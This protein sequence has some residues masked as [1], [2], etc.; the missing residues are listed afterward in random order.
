MIQLDVKTAGSHV[1]FHVLLPA[2]AEPRSV[3]H[4]GL[5]LPFQ[6]AD[7]EQSRYVNFEVS[8]ARQARLDIALR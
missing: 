3:R 8:I 7:V 5:E 6:W 1:G 4:D 2:G